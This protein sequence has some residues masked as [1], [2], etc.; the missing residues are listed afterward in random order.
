VRILGWDFST[1][2]VL[3]RQMFPKLHLD[4]RTHPR[5][6]FQAD[7]THPFGAAHHQKI[8]VVDDGVAYSGGLDLTTRRWDTREHPAASPARMDPEGAP[9]RAFHDAQVLVAGEA[10]RALAQIA[11][12]R[13]RR[14]TGEDVRLLEPL[15]LESAWPAHV[16]PDAEDAQVVISRT[17]GASDD[18]P[19]IREVRGALLEEI[20]AAKRLL[21]I[22]N[23]YLSSQEIGDAL[24]A[25]LEEPD[26]PEVV[27]VLPR[28]SMGWLEYRSMTVP[29]KK[30]V[31]RLKSAPYAE[32]LRVVWPTSGGGEVYVHAKLL[33]ADEM[34]ARVGSA[35][36]SRR[37][38]MLDTECDLTI[39]SDGDARTARAIGRFRD[40]LLAEHLGVT[41]AEIEGRR[42]EGWTVCRM[43]DELGSPERDLVPV[44]DEPPSEE[45]VSWL[46]AI[47]DPEAPLDAENLLILM[48]ATPRRARLVRTAG[49]VLLVTLFALGA[50]L[51]IGSLR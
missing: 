48:G 39:V 2:F 6:T 41:V 30:I 37:S 5:V 18:E 1:V 47:A 31:S 22:E 24:Y 28:K 36:L 35:N 15:E 16:R 20:R 10:A 40:G 14:A 25:R 45:E 11:R 13:W 50:A 23:Q 43:I 12:E 26:G 3:E 9:Y 34:S 51:F 42:D 19:S 21:Y 7:N 46:A 38:L 29:R 32:R 33:V 27:I 4:W 49:L 44:E 8:V 17:R